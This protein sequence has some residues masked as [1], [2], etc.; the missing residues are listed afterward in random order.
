[1]P[2]IPIYPMVMSPQIGVGSLIP[3]GTAINVAAAT[4][5][6]LIDWSC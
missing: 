2:L 4:L 1:M 3:K 6:E 5:V